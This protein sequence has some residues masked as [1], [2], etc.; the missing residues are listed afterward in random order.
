MTIG[1]NRLLQQPHDANAVELGHLQVEEGD[2]RFFAFD[3]GHGLEAGHGFTH[4]GHVVERSEERDE[5]GPRRAFVINDD[6]A[7]TRRSTRDRARAG[8]H[9]LVH[10]RQTDLDG[11]ARA[12]RG[13]EHERRSVAVLAVEP[14][15]EVPEAHAVVA[16]AG[17][18]GVGR[19]G[20]GVT[21]RGAWADATRPRRRGSGPVRSRGRLREAGAMPCFTAFSTRGW[22]TSGG[23]R[24]CRA[25]G[26]TSIVTRRRSSKRARSMSR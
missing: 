12:G 14:P 24:S 16:P 25:S 17:H 23:T 4:E 21:A 5:E 9:G 10:E 3:E 8:V 1:R 11:R 19:A 6:D 15:L 20:A 7:E 26:G 2:V 18:T 22:R 13:A